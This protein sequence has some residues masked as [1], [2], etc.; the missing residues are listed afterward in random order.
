MP[1][2]DPVINHRNNQ[3]PAQHDN[4][5]V[6]RHRRDWACKRPSQEK[7]QWCQECERSDVD[8]NFPSEQ[9]GAVEATVDNTADGKI[10]G[11]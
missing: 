1:C 2:L 9:C 8:D 4:R 10:V 5:P 7:D 6:H 11:D 3:R